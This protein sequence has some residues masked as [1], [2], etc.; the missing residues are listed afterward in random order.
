MAEQTKEMADA[1]ARYADAYRRYQLS[2]D[3]QPYNLEV[4]VQYATLDKAN[5]VKHMSEDDAVYV[6][7]D[8]AEY[9]LEALK[10]S[11]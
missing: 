2:K 5:M 11:V 1:L 7:N 9:L 6:V 10:A 3:V 4:A 8:E